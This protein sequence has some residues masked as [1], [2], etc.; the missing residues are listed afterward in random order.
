MHYIVFDLEWNGAG[1]ANKVPKAIQDA[2]PFEIIEIGAVKLD[3]QFRL[4]GKFSTQIRPRLYPILTGPV[5]AVT[6]RHQ[7]S[8]KYG[9]DFRDAAR[10]FLAFCGDEY[11]FCTWSE[12]DTATLLMNLRYYQLADRLEMPCIDVQYL[13]DQLVEQADMQRSIEYAID[14]LDLPKPQPFHQAV[15][16]AW[17]TGQ[18]FRHIAEL[19][20]TENNGTDLA[21]RY[22]F[23][24][25]L[26]RSSQLTL[27]PLA[28]QE[29]I[30]PA[31]DT[32]EANCPG[33]GTPLR[34]EQ[35]WEAEK[36][37]FTAAFSCPD[38]GL[39]LAKCRWRRKQPGQFFAYLSLRISRDQALA[40]EIEQQQSERRQ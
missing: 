34:L 18:I 22:A 14:F 4:A 32:L 8:M 35:P 15:N 25:N 12:S 16:D 40:Q 38:H 39:I 2:I 23:D 17:Y 9:L 20:R 3:E 30:G 29:A 33:C 26:N 24:P 31:L 6:R 28:N 1:R 11:L 37:R 5:A 10:D 27:G 13:F 19:N 7:Q 36:S 21:A